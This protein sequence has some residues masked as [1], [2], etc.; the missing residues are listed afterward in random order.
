MFRKVNGS[1]VKLTL[2]LL[3]K[4]LEKRCLD[5]PVHQ[6]TAKSHHCVTAAHL[7]KIK[8][9]GSSINFGQ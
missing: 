3:V 8:D 4:R 6:N 5:H 2:A 7:M 1:K 9:V